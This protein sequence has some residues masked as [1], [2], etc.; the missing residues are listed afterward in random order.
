[1][2][3]Q[4]EGLA[5]E[6]EVALFVVD[7]QETWHNTFAEI[8]A[9]DVGTVRDIMTASYDGSSKLR[10]C[11]VPIVVVCLLL[12]CLDMALRSSVVFAPATASPRHNDVVEKALVQSGILQLFERK[13]LRQDRHADPKTKSALKTIHRSLSDMKENPLAFPTASCVVQVVLVAS[14]VGQLGVILDGVVENCHNR[15]LYADWLKTRANFDENAFIQWAK[16][17][18]NVTGLDAKDRQRLLHILNRG[19]SIGI[20]ASVA[21]FA[22]IAAFL[23]G[24]ANTCAMSMK[25]APN[26]GAQC[27]TDIG[28]LSGA[29]AYLAAAAETVEATCPPRPLL[30]KYPALAYLESLSIAQVFNRRLQYN[31]TTFQHNRRLQSRS[32]RATTS[33]PRLGREKLTFGRNQPQV[34]KDRRLVEQANMNGTIQAN[35]KLLP[36]FGPLGSFTAK[37]QAEYDKKKAGNNHTQKVEL[38]AKCAM[39]VTGVVTFSSALGIFLTAGTMEC[40]QIDKLGKSTKLGQKNANGLWHGHISCSGSLSCNR[41][42]HLHTVA[43]VP[44]SSR[45]C[46]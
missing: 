6:A 4:G 27:A 1:M 18:F 14:V 32:A 26:L 35:V 20:E 22:F 21:L 44:N 29:I 46:W 7:E 45:H 15:D 33:E 39:D 38:Q 16:E 9:D 5:P 24:A 11:T 31:G 17:R 10:R 23:A 2:S 8:E 42:L 12:C 28:L 36:H 25:A 41:W 19:C 30:D 13:A 34:K 37:T 3:R 43:G 40:P